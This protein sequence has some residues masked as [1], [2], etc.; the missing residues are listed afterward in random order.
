MARRP[1]FWARADDGHVLVHRGF[2][3]HRTEADAIAALESGI[4]DMIEV[5]QSRIAKCRKSLRAIRAGKVT[6]TWKERK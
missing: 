6:R 4:N 3:E 5:C 1:R 2:G